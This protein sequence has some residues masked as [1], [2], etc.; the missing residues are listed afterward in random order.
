MGYYTYLKPFIYYTSY[1]QRTYKL[2]Q[3]SKN[4]LGLKG[5]NRSTLV[6]EF[7]FAAFPTRWANML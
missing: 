3:I 7:T 5:L 6:C 1:Y 2:L 4:P